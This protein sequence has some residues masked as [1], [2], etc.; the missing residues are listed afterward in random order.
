[1]PCVYI[2]LGF[3]WSCKEIKIPLSSIESCQLS[4][5]FRT[6]SAWYYLSRCVLWGL[7]S[8]SDKFR[9]IFGK[10]SWRYQEIC[11]FEPLNSCWNTLVDYHAITLKQDICLKEAEKTYITFKN[12]E[13]TNYS[14]DHLLMQIKTQIRATFS[15]RN[16]TR[17]LYS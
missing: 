10:F 1:M 6:K 4:R 8:K 16:I 11:I 14:P 12:R 5:H 7:I 17:I 9:V 2:F 13:A 15:W 3:W